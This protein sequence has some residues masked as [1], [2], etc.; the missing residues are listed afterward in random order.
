[1]VPRRPGRRSLSRWR[2]VP[3]EPLQDV[4]LSA[5][6]ARFG[7]RPLAR[8]LLLVPSVTHFVPSCT[9]TLGVALACSAALVAT[10]A[11]ADGLE[12][13]ARDGAPWTGVYICPEV[14][15]DRDCSRGAMVSLAPPDAPEGAA[16]EQH[17]AT[18]IDRGPILR[19]RSLLTENGRAPMES[20]VETDPAIKW[21]VRHELLVLLAEL[22]NRPELRGWVSRYQLKPDIERLRAMRADEELS[23]QRRRATLTE[24]EDETGSER[25]G[26]T[27][28]AFF[29]GATL[30][31]LGAAL[32]SVTPSAEAN[33]PHAKVRPKFGTPGIKLK[34]QFDAF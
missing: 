2:D 14:R 33:T 3:T 30:F 22:A 20:G 15:L 25:G 10:G 18:F 29:A 12:A 24:I 1:M 13:T 9:R 6:A 7:L 16:R 19:E 17:L 32:G 21:R 8:K 4:A 11:R 23:V 26:M 31:T 34:G 5:P 28:E 27:A